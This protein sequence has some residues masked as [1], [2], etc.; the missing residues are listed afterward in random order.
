MAPLRASDTRGGDSAPVA[1]R[2]RASGARLGRR[3]RIAKALVGRHSRTALSLGRPPRA[4]RS[5]LA[6]RSRDA[7][8]TSRR[9]FFR[10]DCKSG[11]LRSAHR[12]GVSGDASRASG[13]GLLRAP[14]A[15]ELVATMAEW[16]PRTPDALPCR[17]CRAERTGR[18]VWNP[19][20][21]M[22]SQV[23]V[24]TVWQTQIRG[25]GG[26][27]LAAGAENAAQRN[28]SN[29]SDSTP[30]PVAQHW[31]P[32]SRGGLRGPGAVEALGFCQGGGGVLGELVRRWGSHPLAFSSWGYAPSTRAVSG[33]ALESSAVVGGVA[34]LVRSFAGRRE[35]DGTTERLTRWGRR[36]TRHSCSV[37][38]AQAGEHASGRV[39]RGQRGGRP[40][41]GCVLRAHSFGVDSCGHARCLAGR[42]G[43]A[44]TGNGDG[45]KRS[46]TSRASDGI[47][48]SA[49][50]SISCSARTAVR[51]P[52]LLES[53][54]DVP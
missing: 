43:A 42:C 16:M 27:R 8:S 5:P 24:G 7:R 51:T 30:V 47:V 26:R 52:C 13:R 34:R 31:Q 41:A 33:G 38:C 15:V 45:S 39:A 25:P 6:H 48:S 17:A 44:A 14:S 28:D 49:C 3:L 40:A 22:F 35:A 53:R 46:E 11:A 10:N 29:L 37:R 1:C 12:P 18:Q 36:A 23:E 2:S 21:T 50:G 54:D 4:A 20:V 19:R 9:S 32:P